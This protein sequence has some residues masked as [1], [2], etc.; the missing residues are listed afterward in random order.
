MF[1]LDNEYLEYYAYFTRFK[2]RADRIFALQSKHHTIQKEAESVGKHK[3]K[4]CFP[5]QTL[6]ALEHK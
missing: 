4:Q 3:F 1:I 6:C 5:L 2:L